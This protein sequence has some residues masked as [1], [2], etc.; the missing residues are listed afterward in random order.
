MFC[1]THCCKQCKRTSNALH[2]CGV[3]A[4]LLSKYFVAISKP[5]TVVS[6]NI[7]SLYSWD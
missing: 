1:N 3:P 6:L 4:I 5:G 7:S 2:R